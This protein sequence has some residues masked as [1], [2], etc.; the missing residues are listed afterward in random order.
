[1]LE[2]LTSNELKGSE[3]KIGIVVDNAGYELF[4]DLL[5]GHCL[6]ELG[7]YIYIYMYVY[8]YVHIYMYV[9][10]YVFTWIHIYIYIYIYTY[11]YI[12][13][14]TSKYYI[15]ILIYIGVATSITYYT[16]G[17][18]TFVSDATNGNA[19]YMINIQH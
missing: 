5:L 1:L 10:I 19:L 17:H 2:K 18:P 7:I 4:S 16:K 9:C 15:Y 11:I 13:T 8:M 12:H 14:Y 3:R 6:L